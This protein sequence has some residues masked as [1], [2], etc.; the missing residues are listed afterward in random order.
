M[1]NFILEKLKGP[2]D[3]LRRESSNRELT[4]CE[5]VAKAMKNVTEK[6][7][8]LKLSINSIDHAADNNT[9]KFHN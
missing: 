6:R 3:T 2:Q 4:F 7:A 8:K 5:E 1:H 9:P